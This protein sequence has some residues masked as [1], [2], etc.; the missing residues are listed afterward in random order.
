MNLVDG[1]EPGPALIARALELRAGARPR[2]FPGLG[3]ETLRADPV[4]E[5]FSHY[6]GGQPANR[7]ADV[8]VRSRRG[9]CQSICRRAAR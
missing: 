5:A 6:P 3:L 2:Q 9:K 1:S 8:N 7:V 4:G